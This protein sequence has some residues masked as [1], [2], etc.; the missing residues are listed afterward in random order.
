[1]TLPTDPLVELVH[2]ADLKFDP[3]NPRTISTHEFESLQRSIDSFGMVEPLVVNKRNMVIVGGHQ[4]ARAAKELGVERVP[5]AWVDLDEKRQ[6]ALNIALNKISGEFDKDQLAE[7]ILELDDELLDLT[8]FDTAE[9]DALQ[10]APD[11][12]EDPKEDKP[13]DKKY[14][15]EELRT[16][17]KGIY[18]A[19][20]DVILDFL[21]AVGRASN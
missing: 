3:K 12:D 21:E 2:V 1:M 5:V 18:P 19:K 4:R 11:F 14:S 10:A 20:A 9:L 17:A 6:H 7:L 15:L 13:K 16:L 8:G